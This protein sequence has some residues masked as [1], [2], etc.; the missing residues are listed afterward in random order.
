MRE[1]S[2]DN[3]CQTATSSKNAKTHIDFSVV[4]PI[5]NEEESIRELFNRLTAV[6]ESL[7]NTDKNQ[8][9]TFE[10]IMVDDGSTDSSWQLIKNLHQKDSRLKGI[11]FSRNF[12]HHIALTAGLDYA[13]G[14]SIV[15]MDGDLQDPPEEIP[16]LFGKYK[17][18]YDL[19]YGIR[20]DRQDP[21]L[22]KF[23][24]YLFWFLL[25][26]FSGV[27][28][29]AGQTMLRIMSRRIVN[30]VKDMREQ[31]RF[32]HGM[33]AWAGFNVTTLEVKH[34]PRV[35]GKSKYNISKMF[36]LAFHAVTSFSVVPLRLAT[37]F[38][39][40][41]SF[42]SILFGIYFIYKTVI[43]GIPVLGYASIIVSIFFV[44]GIQL[45][46]LGV[47]GEYIGRTYQ[48][49]QKRPLYIVQDYLS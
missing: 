43:Y 21:L 39:L 15:L 23:T 10:I 1:Y 26:K 44:G 37:F 11:S 6:L 5:H 18:G 16:V 19:V 36:M 38:G 45:L 20:K 32:I 9:N 3:S 34:N 14:D 13:K 8:P 7:L 24:S 22:K 40:L 2:A 30:V 41:C 25:R 17:E 42:I 4:I 31:A 49:G 28:I 47:F 48:E 29:P 12:G 27:D 33:M 35:K 46:V